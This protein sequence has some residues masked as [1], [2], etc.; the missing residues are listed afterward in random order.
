M[1]NISYCSLCFVPNARIHWKQI[2]CLEFV[3]FTLKVLMTGAQTASTPYLKFDFNL[4]SN[5]LPLFFP[6]FFSPSTYTLVI[7][8]YIRL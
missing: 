4:L 5:S 3:A 7:L 8:I 2:L 6:L 1:S